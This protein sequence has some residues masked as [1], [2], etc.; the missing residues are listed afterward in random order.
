[1]V[2]YYQKKMLKILL[3]FGFLDLKLPVSIYLYNK[4]K[5]VNIIKSIYWF[6]AFLH[7]SL[8]SILYKN[9]QV[10]IMFHCYFVGK[11]WEEEKYPQNIPSIA[12]VFCCPIY[13]FIN[14]YIGYSFFADIHLIIIFSANPHTDYFSTPIGGN[15]SEGCEQIW[16]CF[17]LNLSQRIAGEL[18]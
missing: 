2:F 12:T 4:K 3:I 7:H 11:L 15:F 6:V 18:K 1:M 14:F 17:K 13:N 16:I 8:F 5:N 9:F 10:Q